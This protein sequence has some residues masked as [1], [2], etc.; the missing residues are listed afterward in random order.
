MT[1]SLP[2]LAVAALLVLAGCITPAEQATPADVP[3]VLPPTVSGL[4]L[5]NATG[6]LADPAALNLTLPTFFVTPV[7]RG[8][9]PTLGVTKNGYIFTVANTKVM[10][11]VD[12]GRNW[13]DVTPAYG[14]PVTLDPLLHVD[15][16][17][18]RVYANQLYVGC[19]HLAWSDDYGK[20]WLFNPA[21]CGLPVNDHQT[22][23]TGK[24]AGPVPLAPGAKSVLYYGFNQLV[25]SKVAASRD[26]GLTFGPA[27]TAVRDGCGGLN[28]HLATGPKGEVYLPKGTCERGPTVGVSLDNGL[29]WSQTFV[30]D[31]VGYN[32]PGDDPAIAVDTNGTVYLV[33]VGKDALMYLSTSADQGKTW[34]APVRASPPGVTSTLFPTLVAGDDGRI[35]LAYYGTTRDTSDWEDSQGEPSVWSADAPEDTTWHLYVGMSL[36]ATSA[37]P[38]FLTQQVTPDADPIQRGSIWNGGGGRPDRNLLDFFDIVRD[39]EGRVY[40]AFTDGCLEKC[41][42]PSSSRSRMVTVAVLDMGPSLLAAVPAFAAAPVPATR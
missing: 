1:R 5:H 17:N 30:S 33:W 37:D 41:K 38:T 7:A 15:Q 11:S 13:T 27:M 3:E 32:T 9:E 10:R 4:T 24:A 20:T 18:D 39:T 2:Y 19:S 23:T 12:G 28:G 40:V 42:D 14:F 22:L 31:E 25:D 35:A 8:A 16:E 36:H 29:T 34:S 6:L 21:A 26:G